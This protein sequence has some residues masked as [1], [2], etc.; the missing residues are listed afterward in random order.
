M[1]KPLRTLGATFILLW[2]QLSPGGQMQLRTGVQTLPGKLPAAEQNGGGIAQDFE[3]AKE[4]FYIWTPTG[5]GATQPYGLLV[6]ISPSDDCTAVPQGWASVLKERRLIFVAP[7][8]AGNKQLVGRRAGLAVVAANKLL[9]MTRIDTNR[10]YVAGFS[11]GARTASYCA[12]VRPSLFS[13]AFAVCGVDFPGQ[14]P[15][16]K[17]TKDDEYGS[18]SLGEQEVAEAKRR[19]KFVLVTG[20]RDFRYGN[21]LDIY[22][23]GFQKDNFAVKLIDVPGMTHTV[24]SAK[25]LSDGISFMDKKAPSA[26][27]GR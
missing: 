24:C 6:Y 18:F 12:F 25:A 3:L 13:G 23:G 19:V 2:A 7:Q 1:R 27:A 21:I 26:P 5:S 17:A 14:V 8:K 16:V 20:S 15:R 4:T 22:T 10:V 11:G 9:E